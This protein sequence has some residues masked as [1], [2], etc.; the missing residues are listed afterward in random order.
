MPRRLLKRIPSHPEKLKSPWLHKLFGKSLLAHDLWHINRRSVAT[1]FFVGLFCGFLPIPVQMPLAAAMAIKARCH[2]PLSVTLVW[3]SN[4]I[5]MPAIFYG[6]YVLGAVLLNLEVLAPNN[7]LTF[8][9]IKAPLHILWPPLLVG[10]LTA[11]LLAGC[12]GYISIRAAW[13]FSVI[14]RWKNRRK[15]PRQ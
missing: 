8:E 10:S 3:V 9:V 12:I 2:L 5:T 7:G 4:P 6:N 14:R 15:H 11:A 1:A 13:R